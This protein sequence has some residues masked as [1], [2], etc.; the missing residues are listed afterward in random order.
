[1]VDSTSRQLPALVAAA[2][3]DGLHV[4]FALSNPALGMRDNLV[5]FGDEALPRLPDGGLVSWLHT[6][7]LLHRLVHAL[8]WG[9]HFLYASSGPSLGQWL[10]AHGAGGRPVAGAVRLDDHGDPFNHLRTGQV[11]ELGGGT[12]NSS[13]DEL[14]RLNQDLLLHHLRAVPVGRLLRD[15]GTPV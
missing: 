9:H 15:S 10:F 14:A 6:R 1:M 11:I 8:G 12:L 4:S 7:A 3:A 13:L 2:R 5:D